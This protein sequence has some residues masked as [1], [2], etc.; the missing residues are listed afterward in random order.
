MLM[1]IKK[2]NW[3][4]CKNILC[5]R[6]DNMGDLI[7]SGPAIR[8]LRSSFR[9][10]I[11][12]LTSTMAAPI[13]Y[14]MEEIDNVIVC[15]MAWVKNCGGNTDVSFN[16]LVEKLEGRN[17][18]AAVIFTVYSQ[19]PI[20]SVLLAY[21]AGI[22]LRLAYCRENPYQLLTDW[23][24]DKEPY[25][26]IRH[27]VRRDLDLVASI[28]ASASKDHLHL[29]VDAGLWPGVKDKL[30]WL[31]LN[32]DK[33]WL[34]LHA[35]V[36]EVKRAYPLDQWIQAGKKIVDELGYQIVLTGSE[37]EKVLTDQLQ[38]RIGESSFSAGGLFTIEELITLMSESSLLL[39]VNTG[40]VHIAAA[41]GT[42][43]VVLYALT[44]PQHTPWKVPC[45]VLPFMVDKELHSKNQVIEFVNRFYYNEKTDLPD[46]VDIVKAVKAILAAPEKFKD[47][48]LMLIDWIKEH[49]N[50]P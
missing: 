31:S 10:N 37:S 18:D 12:L 14:C 27:Q 8:A 49:R 21:F 28:G 15:D 9:A 25:D 30:L 22:P 23:V 19:N 2:S 38:Q 47:Q 7:M 16:R 4:K 45:R 44:N 26:F 6:P 3:Q 50:L 33:N 24:P 1:Q 13:A 46:A 20:P 35:G 42:P 48:E 40:T 11:T 41:V 34:I 32:T 43:V 29:K 17:F 36:S 5:I 39:S